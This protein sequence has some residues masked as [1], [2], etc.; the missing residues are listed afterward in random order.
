MVLSSAL[1]VVQRRR[2]Q[3]RGDTRSQNSITRRGAR[4]PQSD[5]VSSGKS[6]RADPLS[7]FVWRESGGRGR[8]NGSWVDGLA[9]ALFWRVQAHHA[10]SARLPASGA[11]ALCPD[12]VVR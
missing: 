11:G 12:L 1:L 9:S 6:R 4:P 10:R 5:L 7:Y 8:G 2:R 3:S